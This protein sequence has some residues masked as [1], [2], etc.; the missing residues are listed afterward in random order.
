MLITL[1]LLFNGLKKNSIHACLNI[2]MYFE[3]FIHNVTEFVSNLPFS[4]SNIWAYIC[5]PP[6]P[7]SPSLVCI[8][9]LNMT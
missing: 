3:S 8:S 5:A 6:W 1:I 7:D 9:K 2:C 4:S